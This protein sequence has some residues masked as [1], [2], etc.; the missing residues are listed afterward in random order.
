MRVFQLM[1]ILAS[2]VALA[3]NAADD[4]GGW[5]NAKWGMTEDQ[6]KAAFPQTTQ[7]EDQGRTG[8]G[9]PSYVISNRKYLVAFS[10]D[11]EKG[12]TSVH[13]TDQKTLVK[14]DGT[15]V[16]LVR[17]DTC[18]SPSQSNTSSSRAARKKAAD[19]AA[20]AATKKAYIEAELNE[21][22][23][24]LGKESLLTALTEKY[25]NPSS[26]AMEPSGIEKFV[27]QFPTTVITLMWI[28]GEFKQLHSAQ[29]FYG[30]R[31][32]SSDL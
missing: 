27:W 20:W 32:K 1:A 15:E 9:L 26:H 14:N 12:L 21:Q 31:K 24:R 19:D 28:H 16:P 29:L 7:M 3:Q 22:A 6:I 13:F 5:T 8:L 11:K 18:A 10:F 17:C 23:V 2:G 30:L 4:P 25:G